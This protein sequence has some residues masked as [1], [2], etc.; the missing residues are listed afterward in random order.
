[1]QRLHEKLDCIEQF[2]ASAE[3]QRSTGEGSSLQACRLEGSINSS[4][5]MYSSHNDT[6]GFT[7]VV[8]RK[9]A[10]LLRHLSVYTD[11]FWPGAKVL[12]RLLDR[13]LQDLKSEF[14][15]YH[16]LEHV[17]VYSPDFD[18]HLENVRVVLGRLCS[19]GLT[20]QP[21]TV[22]F[23]TQD[24]SFLGHLVSSSS[25]RINPK[26]PAR[27]GSFLFLAMPRL[28]GALLVW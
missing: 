22:V 23:A 2:M 27:V 3:H 10:N 5:L 24:I 15:L 14:F 12:T 19:V 26:V 16:Y 8:Y 9:L 17:V 6:V 4:K 21:D 7:S 18:S 28:S 11:P 1:V 20:V 13:V 25:V